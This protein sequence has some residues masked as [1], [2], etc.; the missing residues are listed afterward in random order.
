MSEQLAIEVEP[1]G[2]QGESVWRKE[3]EIWEVQYSWR[4]ARE[5]EGTKAVLT[6][7]TTA[8][9]AP[10]LTPGFVQPGKENM[11]IYS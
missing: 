2:C 8:V 4:F 10:G 3:K 5:E 9:H 7:M 6:I 1:E 11:H